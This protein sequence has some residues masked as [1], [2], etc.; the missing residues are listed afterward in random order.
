MPYVN[1]GHGPR[2]ASQDRTSHS[3]R[4]GKKKEKKRSKSG[5]V[6][7]IARALKQLNPIKA[8]TQHRE[9]CAECSRSTE[10][11]RPGPTIAQFS[12][13]RGSRARRTA[14][15]AAGQHPTAPRAVCRHPTSHS[16]V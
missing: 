2:A 14:Q 12:V 3:S 9:A 6:I 5:L 15:H 16:P 4:V 11:E 8:S 13:V 10:R 7:D 1:T